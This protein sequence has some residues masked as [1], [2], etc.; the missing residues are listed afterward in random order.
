MSITSDFELSE[1]DSTLPYV[2]DSG[3]ISEKDGDDSNVAYRVGWEPGVEIEV[4]S[5]EDSAAEIELWTHK[6]VTTNEPAPF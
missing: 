6:F 1:T 4:E 2:D 3:N 5:D